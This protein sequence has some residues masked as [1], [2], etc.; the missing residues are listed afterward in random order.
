MEIKLGTFQVCVKCHKEQPEAEFI[1]KRLECKKCVARELSRA[2]MRRKYHRDASKRTM[3]DRAERKHVKDDATLAKNRLRAAKT[4]FKGLVAIPKARLR[5]LA[6]RQCS[7]APPTDTMQRH[8]AAIDQLEQAYA[9]QYAAIMAGNAPKDIMVYM[10]PEE[11][12][13]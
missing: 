12:E 6:Y 2:C 9:K 8:Q 3:V 5:S 10:Q 4:I 13:A 11:E 7:G 1:K